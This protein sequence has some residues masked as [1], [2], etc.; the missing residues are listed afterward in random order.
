MIPVAQIIDVLPATS[1]TLDICKHSQRH[2]LRL[3]FFFSE[4]GKYFIIKHPALQIM[5]LK[6]H[7]LSYYINNPN[8]HMLKK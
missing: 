5:I 2:G 7:H 8:P 6:V 1:I 4:D 3:N